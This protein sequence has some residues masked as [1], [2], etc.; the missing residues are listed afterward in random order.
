MKLRTSYGLVGSDVAMGNRYLYNQVYENGNSYYFS[1]YEAETFPGY[2]EGA[3]GNDNVTWEKAKKFDLGIDLNLFNCVSLTFDYFYDKRYDQLVY[4]N[5]I[6]LVNIARTTNQGFDGQIGYRQK[7][8]DFQFNTNFVFSYA[9]NKI[10][11]QA[12]AQQIYPWLAS[13]GHSIGQPFGY[14]W[15]GYYTPDDIAK[16]KAGA[17]DAPYLTLLWVG[18]WVVLGKA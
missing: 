16:I 6:P 18:P 2:K 1:E 14:T 8:G 13:T 3:L 11:Y 9:K 17:T 12:E 4:R 7:F 5:D 15:E 10:E